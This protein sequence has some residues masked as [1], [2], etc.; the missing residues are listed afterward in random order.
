VLHIQEWL[1]QNVY[2]T[3]YSNVSIAAFTH[4]LA[5]FLLGNTSLSLNHYMP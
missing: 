3:L 1:L 4:H 5:V 2:E